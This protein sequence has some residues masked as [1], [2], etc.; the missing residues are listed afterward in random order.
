MTKKTMM[1]CIVPAIQKASLGYTDIEEGSKHR[2]DI[3]AV[4]EAEAG[5]MNA[6]ERDTHELKV[7]LLYRPVPET[8]DRF[9]QAGDVF[10]IID[11]GGGTVDFGV[12]RVSYESPLR[13]AEQVRFPSGKFKSS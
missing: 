4:Y 2:V 12:Y 3:S 7:H 5:A 13:L 11:A 10:T 8:T 9:R 6:L 1:D